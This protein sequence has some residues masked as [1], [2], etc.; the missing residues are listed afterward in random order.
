VADRSHPTSTEAAAQEP[1][2]Y[3]IPP[4]SFRDH[5][6]P[7]NTIE[8]ALSVV[9]RT[10]APL[11]AALIKSADAGRIS[12]DLTIEY[13]PFLVMQWMRT[14]TFRDTMHEL[15]QKSIQSMA[16]DLA[17]ENFPGASK[18]R[19]VLGDNAMAAMHS[20]K[21]FDQEAVERMADNLERHYWVVGINDTEH[22]LYTSDHPVVRRGNQTRDG[23][24]L[25]GV[26]DPGVEF[27]FPLDS[28]H[29]LLILECTHFAEWR[30][31][32]NRAVPF[33]ADQVRDYN[34]LQVMRSSQRVFCSENDFGLAR[35]VCTA[36]PEIRDPNRP[37]VRVE[38]TPIKDMKNYMTVTALE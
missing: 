2:F 3:E 38:T 24:R 18:P 9:E 36:H 35:E 37:R 32:D 28:R 20:Q 30:K 1:Y 26:R 27:A 12:A 25:V 7:V 21:L 33:T 13:A 34:G 22:P 15:T 16:D 8:K 5:N 19:V 17:A 6:V 14:K 10:W 23:R 11:H 29:I 31:P 4:G